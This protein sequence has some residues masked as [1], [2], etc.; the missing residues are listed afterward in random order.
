MI[1][2]SF[3]YVEA[4]SLE[5]ALGLL[6]ASAGEGKLLAGGHSLLPLMKTRHLTPRLV[7]DIG[8]LHQLRT[9][10]VSPEKVEIGALATHAQIARHEEL[11]RRLP[12]LRETALQ[13]ADP[14]VRNR[15]T[16]GGAV[17]Q[18]G[19]AFDWPA[20]LLA[21]DARLT[22]TSLRGTREVSAASFFSAEATALERD[23]LVTLISIPLLQQPAGASY[24]KLRH[25]AHPPFAS[26]IAGIAVL[27]TWG[28]RTI[29]SCT[30]GVTG[31]ASRPYLAE[32]AARHLAGAQ[33]SESSYARA[34][35]DV[36]RGIEVIGD[37]FADAR[38]RSALAVT[39]TTRALM[40][41][42]ARKEQEGKPD[43]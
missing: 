21:L 40:R 20:V 16:I 27:L 22:L 23:E 18:H 36:V 41:A 14:L 24:I 35:G 26:V 2:A 3:R 1:P 15:G 17:A 32:E 13:I 39:L 29:R 12:I 5:D 43:G 7:I 28:G 34:A 38:Y 6:K 31:V 30:I 9:I 37:R 25:P 8:R 4:V 19:A 11:G 33:P 42:T 10:R